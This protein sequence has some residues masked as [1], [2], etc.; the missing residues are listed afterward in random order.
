MA[1]TYRSNYLS[2]WQRAKGKKQLV[3][4][5][6]IKTYAEDDNRNSAYFEKLNT[7]S[8]SQD[9]GSDDYYFHSKFL[10]NFKSYDEFIK[11]FPN[12]I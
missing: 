11:N 1:R 3:S 7:K 10:G 2:Q 4:I 5:G 8:I 12:Y 9:D 6:K